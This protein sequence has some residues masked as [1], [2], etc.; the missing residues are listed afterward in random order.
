MCEP[1][2][3]AVEVGGGVKTKGCSDRLDLVN[4]QH[5]T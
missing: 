4:S 3:V 2:T 5:R 1:V